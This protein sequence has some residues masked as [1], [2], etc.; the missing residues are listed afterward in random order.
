M[1]DKPETIF[2]VIDTILR[3]CRV[4]EERAENYRRRAAKAIW[5]DRAEI[6]AMLEEKHD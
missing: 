3:D 5:R 4:P 2:E 1:S 6:T